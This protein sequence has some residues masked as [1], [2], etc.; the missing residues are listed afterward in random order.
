MRAAE[1]LELVNMVTKL[2]SNLEDYKHMLLEIKMKEVESN[3]FA[4]EE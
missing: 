3:G 2:I 1:I 4:E